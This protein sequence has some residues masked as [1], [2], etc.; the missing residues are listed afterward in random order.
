MFKKKLTKTTAMKSETHFRKEA[1]EN[2]RG[3]VSKENS[4]IGKVGALQNF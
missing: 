1:I 3:K 2:C 4:I